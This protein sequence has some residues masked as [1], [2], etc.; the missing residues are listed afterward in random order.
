MKTL[1]KIAVALVLLGAAVPV[2]I[3][4]AV[5][6]VVVGIWKRVKVDREML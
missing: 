2:L 4:A 5:A 3:V 6:S 1:M